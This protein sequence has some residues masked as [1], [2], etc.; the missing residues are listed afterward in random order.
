MKDEKALSGRPFAQQSVIA[1]DE[2]TKKVEPI[3]AL[4]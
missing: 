3:F 4:K 2:Q 1:A